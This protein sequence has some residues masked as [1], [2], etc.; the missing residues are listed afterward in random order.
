MKHLIISVHG[1]RTFGDWQERLERLLA[2][3]SSDR[4]LTVI[5]YKYGYFSVVAFV[6]PFFRWVVVRRFRYFLA[7]VV[8][9]EQWD[10]I[11]LVGHSFGTHIIGWGLYGLR[12]EASPPVNTILFAGSVLK[13]E[14][15]WQVL[16]GRNVQRAINDCGVEDDVLIWNQL[17]VPLTG[18]AGRL[19]FNGGTGRTLRNRFFD[20]GHSGYFLTE[21]RPD[22]SFMR[23]YWVP[24]LLTS[25]EPELVDVRQGS[26]L[27]GIRLTLLNNAEP[28]KLILYISPFIV[29]TLIY[30]GLYHFAEA[31][32][33]RA[34]RTLD[35]ITASSNRRVL[36]L[37]M[38]LQQNNPSLNQEGES[39]KYGTAPASPDSRPEDALSTVDEEVQ[40]RV[41]APA[42][43]EFRRAR[44]K[45][46]TIGAVWSPT[47]QRGS[48]P[49]APCGWA[50]SAAVRLPV[51]GP[52]QSRL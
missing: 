50:R 17:L 9:G 46:P 31:Q 42:V 39:I 32:R 29:L 37:S 30:L 13:S 43:R 16:I 52:R 40:C 22:N 21:G 26:T 24:L 28:I 45:P 47:H 33:D 1:I 11:D 6:I 44:L 5:N 15:P 51:Q 36:R 49:C 4:Q 41:M 20:Y 14:F 48:F 35:Q 8:Q 38:H 23:R 27:G 2:V 25:S 7:A 19:G 12:H 10:R 34:Q 18:M 3:E